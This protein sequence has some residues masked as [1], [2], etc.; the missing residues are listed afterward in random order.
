M[1]TEMKLGGSENNLNVLTSWSAF[2]FSREVF[3]F[4]LRMVVESRRG[5]FTND[6]LLPLICC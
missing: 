5:E 1:E 3:C 4:E 2:S 6:L